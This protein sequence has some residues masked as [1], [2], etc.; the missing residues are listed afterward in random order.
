MTSVRAMNKVILL[1]T[2]TEA[3]TVRHTREGVKM[4]QFTIS[5]RRTWKKMGEPMSRVDMHRC[6]AWNG[7]SGAAFADIVER[8]GFK[9]AR[10]LVEGR[11]EYNMPKDEIVADIHAREKN[12]NRIGLPVYVDVIISEFILWKKEDMPE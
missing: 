10:V 4:T 6:I 8:D 5:T 11:L 2:M 3:P 7:S 9:G 1:G 12:A